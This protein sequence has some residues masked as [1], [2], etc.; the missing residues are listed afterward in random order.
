MRFS[1]GLCSLALLAGS[2]LA[3]PGHDLTE[4]IQERRD[5]LG[6]VKRADLSHCASKLAARR[7]DARNHARRSKLA[8]KIQAKSEQ[9]LANLKS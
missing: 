7:L 3:H 8:G 2:A 4:E 9:H 1:N 6:A 5:F